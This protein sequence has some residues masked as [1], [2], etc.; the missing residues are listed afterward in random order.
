MVSGVLDIGG[1]MRW[2]GG[3]DDQTLRGGYVW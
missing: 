2:Q 3:I 1:A